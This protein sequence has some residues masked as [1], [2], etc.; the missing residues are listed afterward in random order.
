MWGEVDC[1]LRCSLRQGNGIVQQIV[2]AVTGGPA[3]LPGG[4]EAGCSP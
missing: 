3:V 1:E 2:K 4:G